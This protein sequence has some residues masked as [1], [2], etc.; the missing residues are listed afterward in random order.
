MNISSA[1]SA[2][3][4]GSRKGAQASK[5]G[6][7]AS[8]EAVAGGSATADQPGNITKI[9]HHSH[10]VFMGVTMPGGRAD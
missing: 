4:C 1:S 2:C 6:Q 3:G 10:K 5:T 7:A 9:A 8:T